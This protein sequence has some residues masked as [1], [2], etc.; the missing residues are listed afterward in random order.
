MFLQ[1]VLSIA[2]QCQLRITTPATF[3]IT[4][5]QS[6]KHALSQ[7]HDMSI[8]CTATLA[9]DWFLRFEEG[10]RGQH[11]YSCTLL[12]GVVEEVRCR[13]FRPSRGLLFFCISSYR[14][15]SL[16]RLRVVPERTPTLG[17]RRMCVRS[18]VRVQDLD[19]PVA[20]PVTRQNRVDFS[21]HKQWC[22]RP[23]LLHCGAS[24]GNPTVCLNIC[25][26]AIPFA[27][28]TGAENCT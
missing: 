16:A 21:T 24:K 3:L 1:R 9:Q 2:C 7:V 6:R 12:G 8:A 4:C 26:K 18:C 10:A 5:F 28:E 17:V 11:W 13:I 25:L 20:M 15:S 23:F 27:T 22:I 19:S 14:I